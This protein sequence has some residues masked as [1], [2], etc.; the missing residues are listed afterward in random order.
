MTGGTPKNIVVSVHQRLL[1]EARRT[2]QRPRE[3]VRTPPW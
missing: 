1:N 2:A 3:G